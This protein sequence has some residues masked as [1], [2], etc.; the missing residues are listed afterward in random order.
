MSAW[1]YVCAVHVA[2]WLSGAGGLLVG[3]AVMCLMGGLAQLGEDELTALIVVAL[4]PVGLGV[5]WILARVGRPLNR[6][7]FAHRQ[8]HNML[9]FSIRYDRERS[10]R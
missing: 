5:A 2:V 10:R 3:F 9:E 4:A 8:A 7:V 6:Y 1:R